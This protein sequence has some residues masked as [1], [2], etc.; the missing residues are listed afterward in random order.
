MADQFGSPEWGHTTDRALH[1][2]AELRSLAIPPEARGGGGGGG[3]RGRRILVVGAVVLMGLAL[4]GGGIL[5]LPEVSARIFKLPVQTVEVASN[6]QSLLVSTGYAVPQS[7][8]RVGARIAGHIIVANVREGDRVKAGQTLYEFDHAD[9]KVAV[10]A[11][12]ARATAM[13]ARAAA[14]RATA[15]ETELQLQRQKK[16]LTFGASGTAV[17][18]DLSAKQRAASGEASAAAAE[19][20]AASA[21]V[22]SMK[23]GLDNGSV[24]APIDGTVINDPAHVGD[25]VSANQVLVEIADLSKMFIE[26]DVP[27]SHLGDVKVGGACEV[28]LESSP[29][30]KRRAVVD[31][32][33]PRV[34]RA[35]ASALARLRLVDPTDDLMPNMSARVT[36][37]AKAPDPT[38][39]PTRS[40][41]STAVT[42]RHG[43]KGVF[44]VV[45]G[46]AHFA[47]VTPGDESDGHVVLKDGPPLGAEVI[48]QP[49]PDVFEGRKVKQMED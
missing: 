31:E 47:P 30:V 36:F 2:S 23:L 45:D 13:Q 20:V 44:V 40:V 46:R 18:E 29:N 24:K 5:I 38:A 32:L 6:E 25:V 27:E 22:R 28:V 26:T 48:D 7:V 42:K 15:H 39:P 10:E 8:A 37:L 49:T 16:L 33:S 12:R 35:K 3:G 9:Q 19:A 41:P 43:K 11:A 14:A 34:N 4:I 1:E 17:V 21:D